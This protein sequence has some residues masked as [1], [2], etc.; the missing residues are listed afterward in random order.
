MKKINKKLLINWLSLVAVLLVINT[1]SSHFFKRF[2][3]T[4]DKRYT[5]SEHTLELLAS[6]EQPLFIDVFL[7]G[8]FP[9][10]IK[11]LQ[12]ETRQLLEEFKAY[13]SNIQFQFI[14]PLAEEGDK[15]ALI[16]AFYEKGMTPI[17][18]T[19]EDKG[20]QSQ[21]IVFPWAIA[22]SGDKDTKV[23]LL[24][25][26][27][28]AS[29]EEKVISSVQHL[30]YAFANAIATVTKEKSKKV[31]VLKGNGQPEDVFI[32]DALKQIRENYFIAP[33]TLDSVA[34]N[35]EKVLK[36]LQG[37]DLAIMIK[38][39]ER[40]SDEEKLVLDQYVMSGGKMLWLM[41]M[42]SIEMDSLYN[43]TGTSLAYPK[44]LNLN[45]LFF[46]YGVR[47]NPYLI[48]D[49]MAT[50]ISLATGAEGSATQYKQFPWFYAPM[51]YPS[52]KHPIVANLDGL[53][54]EF[55]N[56]ID[57]L[58]N[59]IQKTVL[60]QSSPYSKGIGTPIEVSLEMV[61]E[62]PE[63]TDFQNS[64][65][66][67]VAV[68]LEGNFKSAF[69]NRVLPFKTEG[70]KETSTA[71]KM[72]VVSDGDVIKNQLDKNY[73]PLEL[74][75]DKWT[76]T[77]YGNKEFI[78]NSVNFLLDDSGLINIRS[79]EVNL[80]L[81]DKEKVY[82]NYSLAQWITIG[83]PITI[84]VFFGLLFIYIRKRIYGN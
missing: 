42:V 17:N 79:K 31:V 22:Y 57:T 64:G 84:V 62:R 16:E 69:Q 61:S 71:T 26:M 27:M 32:G 58:K 1:I 60:L 77:Y 3:L 54:F 83:V 68:L 11:R 45:D 56:P 15:D 75:Y 49:I 73:Q 82:D 53:K 21:E 35:P 70:Y 80:P 24:K 67:P 6:I 78:L 2:D 41:D 30:E 72:I 12:V 20:K 18:L 65:L 55:T 14:N 10:D 44:D 33:F 59:N 40:F 37:Y 63:P 5:L 23:P 46:K 43:D 38:P 47:I 48:K 76:N 50:P 39:T 19:V 34:N 8:N 51:I 52:S 28:G 7:D 81:L 9:S 29:T 4:A 13:N 66:L 36:Q 74:G 25:N